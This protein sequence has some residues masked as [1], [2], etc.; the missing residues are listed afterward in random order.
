MK[1]RQGFDKLNPNGSSCPALVS[2]SCRNSA[3]AVPKM[4]VFRDPERSVLDV[5]E[6]RKHGKATFAGQHGQN[7]DTT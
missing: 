6:H 1:E 5:R 7:F 4:V 3:Q 2:R